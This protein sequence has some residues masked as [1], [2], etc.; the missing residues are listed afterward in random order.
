MK[1]I[2]NIKYNYEFAMDMEIF[3]NEL[4]RVK[5]EDCKVLIPNKSSILFL[6]Y[7]I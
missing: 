6:T 5:N 1:I 4:N 7:L 2:S 3:E